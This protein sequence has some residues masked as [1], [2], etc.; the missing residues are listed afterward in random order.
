MTFSIY[1]IILHKHPCNDGLGAV[2]L[3]PRSR[4]P[5]SGRLSKLDDGYI[6]MALL[7]SVIYPTQEQVM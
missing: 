6:V 7:A 3:Q 2:A 4:Y 5:Q 1:H